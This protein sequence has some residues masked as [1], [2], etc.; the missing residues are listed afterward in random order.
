M[1]RY[2]ITTTLPY[3]NAKPHIGFALE[4]I[5]ADALARYYR[6]RGFEVVFNTGTDEHGQKIY[7]KAKEEGKEPQEYVDEYAQKFDALKASL[8][9]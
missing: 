5:Q 3:V 8:N 9:L 2:Y 7:D 1:K 4:I 6:S